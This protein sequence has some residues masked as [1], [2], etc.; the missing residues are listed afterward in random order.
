MRLSGKTALVTGSSSG[1]GR[2]IALGLAHAGAR[3]VAGS[4]NPD[5]VATIKKELGGDHEAVTIDVGN[6]LNT[7]DIVNPSLSTRGLRFCLEN[8]D[9][10]K[11][12]LRAL[13]REKSVA[14]PMKVAMDLRQVASWSTDLRYEVGRLS[15]E[16]AHAF[17]EAVRRI[18]SW[19]D[20]SL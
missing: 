11:A 19:V 1:I 20:K 5:K 15:H 6:D 10:F 9:L 14:L 16:D 18:L 17:L 4:T 8:P 3:V 2:A 13:L 7:W 12:Q